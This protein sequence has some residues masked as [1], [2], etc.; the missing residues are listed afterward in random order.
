M[1]DHISYNLSN[2]GYNVAKYLPFGPFKS[3]IPYLF[4]RAEEN[5]AVE[6]QTSRELFLYSKE[7]K[8]RNYSKL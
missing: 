6:G 4:R 3:V 5:T 1:S 7:I 8:R 2:K